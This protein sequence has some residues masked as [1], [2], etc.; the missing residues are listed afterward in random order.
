M[1]AHNL[2]QDPTHTDWNFA[3]NSMNNNLL[4]KP[5][6]KALKRIAKWYHKVHKVDINQ[7]QRG[8]HNSEKKK[9]KEIQIWSSGPRQLCRSRKS[10]QAKW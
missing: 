2:G 7:A 5:G 1:I 8:R 3:S 4:N 6:W 9:E 10:G